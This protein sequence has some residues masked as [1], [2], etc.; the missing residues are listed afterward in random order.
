MSAW[1]RVRTAG[2]AVAAAVRDPIHP[3]DPAVAVQAATR[4]HRK[5]HRCGAYAYGEGPLPATI[6]AAVGARRIVEVGTALGYTSASM[7]LAVPVAH[8]DTIELDHEHVLLAREQLAGLGL[9]DR[10]T[11]HEGDAV[12]LLATLEAGAYDLA[13]FDGFTPTHEVLL[14]LRDRLRV[15]GSLLAGNLILG[16]EQEVTRELED[17][18][19]WRTCTFGET[20]LCVKRE[21]VE[22]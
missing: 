2:V 21:P 22:R 1:S 9:Q 17:P 16:P 3:D 11:V 15:G 10:V 14:A 18:S 19:R 4:R 12:D 7:A 5:A 20:A 8:V 6:A 13:F